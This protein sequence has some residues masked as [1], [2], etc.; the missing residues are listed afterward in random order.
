[1]NI[2]A[3]NIYLSAFG[4]LCRGAQFT[5]LICEQTPAKMTILYKESPM[6]VN[7]SVLLESRSSV[8]SEY[9]SNP[10]APYFFHELTRRRSLTVRIADRVCSFLAILFTLPFYPFVIAAIKLTSQGPIFTEQRVVGYRGFTFKI[11]TFRTMS[12][13]TPTRL[14]H[15]LHMSRIEYF[16]LFFYVLIGRL[17]LVG[18]TLRTEPT[19]TLLNN[20]VDWFYKVYAAN[21]GI[22]TWASVNGFGFATRDY[23]DQLRQAELD[24]LYVMNQGTAMY[25][26]ILL[27][28]MFD[29]PIKLP[30][31]LDTP[32][33]VVRKAAFNRSAH[34]NRAMN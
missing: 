19:A 14:G 3:I 15:F 18:V 31:T 26:R 27:R 22:V 2:E 1:M 6:T 30:T 20:R 8:N 21:P 4:N 24:I 11:S 33:S 10:T 5:V 28:T 32:L 34:S 9:D 12:G 25:F 17:S 13:Q 16:P 23:S 29:V 7:E